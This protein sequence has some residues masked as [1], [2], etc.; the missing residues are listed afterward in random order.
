MA[1]KEQFE[2]KNSGELEALLLTKGEKDDKAL[3][4]ECQMGSSKH[5]QFVMVS[6]SSI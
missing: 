3:N 2:L 4:Y 6:V 5:Q 1:T